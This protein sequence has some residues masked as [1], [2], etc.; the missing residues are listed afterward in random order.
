M[1]L[2]LHLRRIQGQ[3]T[4]LF[5]NNWCHFHRLLVQQQVAFRDRHKQ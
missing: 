2:R 1:K 3:M 4:P 5:E